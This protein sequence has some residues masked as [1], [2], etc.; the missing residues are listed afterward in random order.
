[1]KLKNFNPADGS[2]DSIVNDDG[3][4]ALTFYQL[5]NSGSHLQLVTGAAGSV[6]L[7]AKS[8][9][10]TA[11]I[12][13]GLWPQ[14]KGG[15]YIQSEI[16]PNWLK[17]SP[18]AAGTDIQVHAGGAPYTHEVGVTVHFQGGASVKLKPPK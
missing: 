1:M 4:P 2:F 17:I 15:L 6:N 8:Y 3:S 16:H 11:D 14:N 18:S 5:G 12:D 9:E 7:D 10:T 13:L